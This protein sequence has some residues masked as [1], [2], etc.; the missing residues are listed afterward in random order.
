MRLHVLGAGTP[1]ADRDRFGTSFV[2]EIGDEPMMVDCGPAATYKLAHVGIRP[3]QVNHLF[4]THH[5]FDHNV[6]YPCF[7]LCRWDQGA[8]RVPILQ[9]AGPPPTQEITDRLIGEHGAFSHDWRAR[10]EHPVSQRMFTDR[11]GTLPRPVPSVDVREVDDGDVIDGG[12][13]SATVARL[14]HAEPWL[15]SVGYRFESEE[16]IAAVVCDAGPNDAM[17]ELARDADLLVIACAFD[18]EYAASH[19]EVPPMITG[20]EDAGRIAQ[21]AGARLA[22]LTHC[23]RG[24]AT[25]GRRERAITEVA[26]HFSGRIIL[27][28]E[29]M[30]IEV[31]V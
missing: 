17:T 6:D 29:L 24:V 31:P 19:P 18:A 20:T 21:S 22:V 8:D 1:D 30:S 11:K 23:N 9:V 14:T 2:L 25:P 27:A 5:H 3:T 26:R 12:T 28:D 13:W 4:F 10:V 15:I 16:G 7:L